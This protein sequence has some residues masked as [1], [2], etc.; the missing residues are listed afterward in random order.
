MA[1]A[2]QL[3]ATVRSGYAAAFTV[4]MHRALAGAGVALLL[5]LILVTFV[6]R[7]SAGLAAGAVQSGPS[8][9]AVEPT[10]EA[11]AAH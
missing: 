5:A 8:R 9:R 7:R 4:G 3:A 6:V 2:K 10:A 11:A 1:Q